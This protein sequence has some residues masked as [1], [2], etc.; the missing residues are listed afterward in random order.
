M[1][2]LLRQCVVKGPL[3]EQLD[4]GS[5][6]PHE[7]KHDSTITEILAVKLYFNLI[8]ISVVKMEPT[9]LAILCFFKF[10]FVLIFQGFIGRC[11]RFHLV[12][13]LLSLHIML[14]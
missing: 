10:I 5:V 6:L 14:T 9:N 8:I 4:S 1:S 2:L 3:F 7:P 13:V 12:G 11:T